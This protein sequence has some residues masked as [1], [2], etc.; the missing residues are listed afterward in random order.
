M[1][2]MA[3]AASHFSIFVKMH[4][5]GGIFIKPDI[6]RMGFLLVM[7]PLTLIRM[8]VISRFA[9]PVW[10]LRGRIRAAKEQELSFVFRSLR[11]D[12]QAMALSRIGDRAGSLGFSE[13]LDY[14][15]F[16]ESL[17]DW[18]VAPHLQRIFLI[19]LLPPATW[20]LAALIQTAVS[21]VMG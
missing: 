4:C 15:V 18:P 13:L 2:I 1:H 10:I 12:Q 11:G 16:I 8:L 17:W 20:V 21:A 5:Q 14:R 9:Y 6:N 3:G 19:G 7:P